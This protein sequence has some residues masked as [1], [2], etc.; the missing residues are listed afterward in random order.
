LRAPLRISYIGHATL[1]IEI[2]GFRLLTDPNFDPHLGRVLRRVAAPIPSLDALRRP[3]AVLVSHAHADH[4]S[5]ASLVAIARTGEVPV[6]APPAV[7]RWV[8]RR[9]YSDARPVSPGDVIRLEA[10]IASRSA[11]ASVT[12]HVGA[13]AHQGSRYGF[14]RWAGRGSSNTYLIDSSEESVFFAG[15]TGLR[16]DS[17]AMVLEKLGPGRRQLDVALLPIGYS[18]WWRP[19]F[20]RHHLSPADALL[21][22]ERLDARMLIPY[23]WGTFHHFSSGPF[24]AVRQLEERLARYPRRTDVRLVPPGSAVEIGGRCAPA[25]SS[26]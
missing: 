24:D 12:I 25:E 15:D 14:D 16:P 26:K 7:T 21:F 6:Y 11:A 19:G 18:P 8:R 17:D 20:R 23:H 13:A 10:P 4:L 5:V 2:A 3:H 22:F 1:L 9:G